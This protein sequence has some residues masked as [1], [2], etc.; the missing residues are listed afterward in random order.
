MPLT[1]EYE[2]SP[3]EWVRNQVELF[4]SS[5]GARGNTVLDDRPV[6]VLTTKGGKSGKLRKSPVMRVEHDGVYAAVA[7]LG[8]APKHPVWYFNLKSTPLVELQDGAERKDYLAREITGEEKAVWWER[9]VAAFPNYAEYQ[10]KT[11]R[12]IPVFLLEPVQGS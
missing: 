8:G 9:A 2:P 3:T 5:D 6:V 4:E 10:T 7:S 12:V 1:G 11:D